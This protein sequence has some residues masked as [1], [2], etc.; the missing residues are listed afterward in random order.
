MIIHAGLSPRRTL[1]LCCYRLSAYKM[2]YVKY[3][4]FAL[5]FIRHSH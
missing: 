1:Q 3:G 4:G 5:K 2:D